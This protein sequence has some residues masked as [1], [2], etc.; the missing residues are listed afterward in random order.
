MTTVKIK[1][2]NTRQHGGAVPFGNATTFIFPFATTSTGAAVDG[3]STGALAVGDV[4]DLGPLPGG[5]RIDDSSIIITTAL[6]ASVTGSLGFKYTDGTDSTAVP[7]DAA[8]F[9]TGLVLSTAARLR[10]ATTK[11]PITL[12]KPA[13]LILTVAGA[14]N[15][16][17]SNVNI[18]IKGELV[19]PV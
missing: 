9:G 18:V 4:V 17:A 7:Q 10:N 11:A 19:G 8:Y 3:D 5:F 12:P 2:T 14:D 16:K 13:R 15:A 6:T 1:N